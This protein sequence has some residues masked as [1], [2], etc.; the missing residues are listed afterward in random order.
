MGGVDYVTTG[1][2][3]VCHTPNGED[4]LDMRRVG[5][6]L[7]IVTE[8]EIYRLVIGEERMRLMPI[9]QFVQEEGRG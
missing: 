4:V 3:D 8:S 9:H 7:Y 1:D 2:E 5:D 6:D